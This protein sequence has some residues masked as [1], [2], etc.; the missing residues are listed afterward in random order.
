MIKK[1]QVICIQ[2][3]QAT[4]AW[5]CFEDGSWAY[6]KSLLYSELVGKRN[7]GPPNL[8]FKDYARRPEELGYNNWWV[9]VACKWP[10]KM[11]MNCTQ[12]TDG[13]RTTILLETKE[14]EEVRS[15]MNFTYLLFVLFIVSLFLKQIFIIYYILFAHYA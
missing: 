12:K 13:K 5:S 9:G 14:N 10:G 4:L 11:E 7:Q 1:N 2:S 6:P 15:R 8:H 3:S